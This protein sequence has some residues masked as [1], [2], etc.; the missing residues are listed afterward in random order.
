MADAAS[1]AA[2][3]GYSLPRVALRHFPPAPLLNR[4]LLMDFE[5][6]NNSPDVVRTH[7]FHGRFENIRLPPASAP[8][9]S[10]VLAEALRHAG[11][12]LGR[13]PRDLRIGGWFNAM[14]P[15]DI[16][17]LHQHDDDAEW[18]SGVYYVSAPWQSGDLVLH[19]PD[20]ALKLSPRAGTFVFFPPSLPHEVDRHNGSALR[21]SVGFNIGPA[22]RPIG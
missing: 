21:L 20:G 6:A 12:L 8:M 1:L 2:R 18:L 15:G 13:H 11:R 16:T 22:A 4:L 14:Q 9:L 5:R 3:P 10:P 7:F 17:S 19:L